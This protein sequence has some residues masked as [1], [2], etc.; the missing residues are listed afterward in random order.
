MSR[1]IGADWKLT[2]TKLTDPMTFIHVC[3]V[4]FCKFCTIFSHFRKLTFWW[5]YILITRVCTLI[6]INLC[7]QC[8]L[9]FVTD[10][11]L[12][13]WLGVIQFRGNSA[14]NLKIASRYSLGWFEITR[15]ITLWIVLY[16]VLLPLLMIASQ[17]NQSWERKIL[18][19]RL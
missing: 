11:K 2:W 10:N 3:F 18:C 12:V 9:H 14:R 15:P 17:I 13:T 4:Q 1:L 19:R 8:F 16:P 7:F 6:I 5:L